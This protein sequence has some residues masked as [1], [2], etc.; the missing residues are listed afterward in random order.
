M[1]KRTKQVN[2]TGPLKLKLD[3]V[4]DIKAAT[5]L[6]TLLSRQRGHDLV[7]DA[8]AVERLGGQ[9]LQILL[10]ARASWAADRRVFTVEG[11]SQGLIATLELMGLEPAAFDHRM[12]P[13]I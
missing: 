11:F 2:A 3:A 7:I 12:E 8:S 5:P 6:F 10:A 13:S 4:L 1:V 9:C